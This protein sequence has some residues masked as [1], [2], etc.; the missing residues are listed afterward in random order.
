VHRSVGAWQA[1]LKTSILES[2]KS[3]QAMPMG[4]WMTSLKPMIGS[5]FTIRPEVQLPISQDIYQCGRY[6]YPTEQFFG[7]LVRW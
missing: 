1:F 2:M 4:K 6:H 3:S 7:F 5:K